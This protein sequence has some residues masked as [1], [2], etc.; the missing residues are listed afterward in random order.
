[1][2][3]WKEVAAG[4]I[5]NV[6]AGF[7]LVLFYVLIQWFLQVT[8]ITIAYCWKW[9]GAPDSAR[10]VR[11]GFDIRN[12]SRSRTYMLSHV[13]YLK[14]GRPVASVDNQSLWGRALGPGCID[15]VE[16]APVASF[17]SLDQAMKSE[18]HVR[19]QGKRLF[20]LQGVGPGQQ[21]KGR[22]QRAAF[23]LRERLERMA[24]P[25]E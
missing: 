23:W 2:G 16:A 7:S 15:L 12:L 6:A 1:M 17:V 10:N 4:F 14:D 19:L 20:W 3:F 5:G 22:L 13:A 21:R 11:P 25:L 18:V 8:D 24:F 9:D